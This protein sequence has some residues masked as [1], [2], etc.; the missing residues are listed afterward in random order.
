MLDQ[1]NRIFDKLR[2]SFREDG[3]DIELVE[4]TADNTVRVKL[5]GSCDGG[6]GGAK[7]IL[8]LEL[9]RALKK[10][11]P[12]IKGVQVVSRSTCSDEHK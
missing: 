10:K 12:A 5:C 1:I 9:E 8:R 4:L 7:I 11:I 2:P 3:H 6:C